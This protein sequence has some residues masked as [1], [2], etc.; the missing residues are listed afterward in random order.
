MAQLEQIE[1]IERQ[2]W[3]TMD[4]LRA[5]PDHASTEYFLPVMGLIYLQHAYS[6]SFAIR[7]EIE[8]GLPGRGGRIRPLREEDSSQKST[9]Y[10]QSE[11]VSDCQVGLSG[12]GD[13][14]RAIIKVM[15]PIESDCKTLP[16]ASARNLITPLLVSSPARPTRVISNRSPAIS[17]AASM[18]ISLPG[19]L[20]R[21]PTMPASSSHRSR[22]SLMLLT[23]PADRGARS[24]R[25]A[26]GLLATLNA[27]RLHVDRWH[28]EEA[29]RDAGRLTIHDILWSSSVGLPVDRYTEDG[30]LVRAK[31]V[32][33]RIPGLSHVPAT[34]LRGGAGSPLS[35]GYRAILNAGPR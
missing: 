17:L 8:A 28:E 20:I 2:L 24:S 35:Q 10:L 4:R 22:S 6:S 18:S 14:A 32:Y 26:A 19:S 25:V 29:T 30:V 3:N 27:E 33:R 16:G 15:K 11:A 13:R 5:N 1:G 7:S 9:I 21:K 12:N 31:D 34:V 23:R